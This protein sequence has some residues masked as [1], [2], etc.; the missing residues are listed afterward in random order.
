MN[1]LHFRHGIPWSYPVSVLSLPY[2]HTSV[3]LQTPKKGG[4]ECFWRNVHKRSLKKSDYWGVLR[5]RKTQFF[6]KKS[7]FQGFRPSWVK[8]CPPSNFCQ[9]VPK[10]SK[11]PFSLIFESYASCLYKSWWFFI[12]FS[13]VQKFKV[14]YLWVLAREITSTPPQRERQW[15]TQIFWPDSDFSCHLAGLSLWVSWVLS[16][17]PPGGHIRETTIFKK[18]L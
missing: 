13:F 18:K 10:T 17:R 7:S 11:R 14:T 8:L 1:F 16:F 6:W 2:S 3:N 9:N 15:E 4:S 12:L 5:L